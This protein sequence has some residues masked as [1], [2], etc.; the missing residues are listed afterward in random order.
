M[1]PLPPGLGLPGE[2]ISVEDMRAYEVNG[3]WLGVSL[4]VLMENAGRSVADYIEYRL[5]GVEG[6]SIVVLAGK[7]GNAGD[8]FVAAR[9]LAS[10]GARVEVHLAYHP[11]LVSHPD[12]RVNFEALVRL[13]SAKIIKPGHRG[14]LDTSGADVVVDALLGTGV[15]GG[16]RSPVREAVEAFNSSQGLRVSID[17]PS[18]VDPDTGV[19]VEGAARADATVTMHRVKRGLLRA[20][21]YTGE[22]VVASIGLPREA[23]VTAGPGDVVAR[24]PARPR[25]SHKGVGG[26]V[27]VVA[28]SA[29]YIGAALLAVEAA[30]RTG[31]DLV[32]VAS[33]RRIVE[34]AAGRTSTA[35]PAPIIG[36]Y[37]SPRDLPGLRGF[38]EKAHAVAIGPGLGRDEQ[39]LEAVAAIIGEAIER[40]K[41][42]VVDADGLHAVTRLGGLGENVVLTPHRGEAARLAGEPGDPHWMA[43]RIAEAYKATVLVKAP[44]DVACSPDGRCRVNRTGVPAMSVG[45]TGDVLTGVIAG[46]LAKRASILGNPDPLNTAIT[47]A[48]IT[49]AAGALAYREYGESMT[50]HDVIEMIPRVL[51]DPLGTAPEPL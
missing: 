33:P 44:V 45:G 38:L 37:L 12:A 17:V 22:I 30:A 39:V 48:Y 24:V 26:R 40:G 19:A 18:G 42:V 31:V 5:G 49:G 25:D 7:G 46:I 21:H 27:L 10:R 3:V 13:G 35:V 47:G 23:E 29:S 4:L 8:G 9:H 6:R 20:R 15:R 32:Y 1:S 14:W 36:D 41:P 28:G 16:L 2:A 11:D 51:G 43:R 50:A 34:A